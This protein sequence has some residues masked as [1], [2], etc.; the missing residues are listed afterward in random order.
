MSTIR[1]LNVEL[2]GGVGTIV[3]AEDNVLSP[4]GGSHPEQSA[5][6][7]P[8]PSQPRRGWGRGTGRGGGRKEDFRG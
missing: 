7:R 2:D 1:F 3:V 4:A 8:T 5:L 6:P